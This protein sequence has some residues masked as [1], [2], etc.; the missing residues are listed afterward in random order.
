MNLHSNKKPQGDINPAFEEEL[1]KSTKQKVDYMKQLIY[2]GYTF[3][4]A[5]LKAE[6]DLKSEY[7]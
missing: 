2:D 3:N 6:R 4:Q 1:K 7:V 5:K